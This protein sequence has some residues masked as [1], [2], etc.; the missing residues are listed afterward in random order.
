MTKKTRA[1]LHALPATL[2]V[3]F[4]AALAMETVFYLIA[5]WGE[6]QL[7]Y[8]GFL[9]A[10]W[11]SVHEWIPVEIATVLTLPCVGYLGWRLLQSAKTAELDLLRD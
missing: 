4:V 6:R 3:A 11:L 9:P 5:V 2:L 10:G 1:L 7:E 8:F